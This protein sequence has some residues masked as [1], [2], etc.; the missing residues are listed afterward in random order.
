MGKWTIHQIREGRRENREGE[1]C[2]EVEKGSSSFW[3]ILNKRVLW[4]IKVEKT[5]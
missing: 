3:D 4:G 5:V 2:M 1:V